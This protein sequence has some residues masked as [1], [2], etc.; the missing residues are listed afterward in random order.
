MSQ[1]VAGWKFNQHET[2]FRNLQLMN[3]SKDY[4]QNFDKPI[5]ILRNVMWETL[6]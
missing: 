1:E 2:R 3:P 4:S 5:V 6:F